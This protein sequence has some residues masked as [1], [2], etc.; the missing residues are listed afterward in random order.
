MEEG[1]ILQ[2]PDE[3]IQE[4]CEELDNK[5]LGRLIRSST[6]FRSVCQEVLDK[7]VKRKC[8]TVLEY[9]NSL[10]SFSITFHDRTK[11]RQEIEQ[12]WVGKLWSGMG[13]GYVGIDWKTRKIDS[14]RYLI[15]RTDIMFI[16]L[17]LTSDGDNYLFFVEPNLQ[18]TFDTIDVTDRKLF[19]HVKPYIEDFINFCINRL[20]PGYIQRQ[21]KWAAEKPWEKIHNATPEEAVEIL[22]N[23][24]W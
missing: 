4:I 6:K 10:P 19:D 1:L 22:K 16:R 24:G 17:E 20:H 8:D 11:L 2:L 9:L 21:R 12:D 3:K 23:L 13:V 14:F 5:S 7:R 15:N 18:Y